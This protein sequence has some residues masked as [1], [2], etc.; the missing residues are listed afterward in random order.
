MFQE[1]ND[2]AWKNVYEETYG[3]KLEYSTEKAE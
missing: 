1:A 3:I 2:D